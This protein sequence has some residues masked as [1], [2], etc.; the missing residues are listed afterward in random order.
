MPVTTITTITIA[1]SG[2]SATVAFGASA[3]YSTG[4]ITLIG[5]PYIGFTQGRRFFTV[6]A[7]T[8]GNGTAT[9]TR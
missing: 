5:S 2:L 9:H 1:A 3:T 6:G 7:P 8:A 4:S